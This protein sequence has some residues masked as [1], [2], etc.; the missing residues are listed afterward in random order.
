MT[1]DEAIY[2]FSIYYGGAQHLPG[3][4]RECGKGWQIVDNRGALSTFDGNGLTRLVVMAHDLCVRVTVG[5]NCARPLDCNMIIAI[6]PRTCREGDITARHPE[7]EYAAEK[8]R[9]GIPA[10]FIKPTP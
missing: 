8:I 4:I 6:H 3:D 1:K 2:F 7:L 9:Q 5:P 10:T